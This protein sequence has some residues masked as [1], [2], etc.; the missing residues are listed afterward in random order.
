[1]IAVYILI[2]FLYYFASAFQSIVIVILKGIKKIH[3]IVSLGGRF[4]IAVKVV[5]FLI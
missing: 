4:N 2:P 5:A 1:M 3:K